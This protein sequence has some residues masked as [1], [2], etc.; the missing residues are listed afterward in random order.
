VS[1]IDADMKMPRSVLVAPDD[2]YIR[3]AGD[4]NSVGLLRDL[5]AMVVP[6]TLKP[7]LNEQQVLAV[8]ER[9]A[10]AGQLSRGAL[11][12]KNPYDSS[13]YVLAERAIETFARA[14]YDAIANVARL[15][16]AR[17][18]HFVEAKIETHTITWVA[19]IKA[20]LQGAA[21]DGS[22]T[23]EVKTRLKTRLEGLI[24]I[25]DPET[26][27][28][29]AMAY[30]ERCNLSGDLELMTLVR[31]RK[32]PGGLLKSRTMKM[33]G[34]QESEA[35]IRSALS[36]ANAGPMKAIQIAPSFTATAQSIREIEIIT[37]I[38]F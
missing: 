7:Q 33:S 27:P 9:L 11:L 31:M 17:E 25:S 5:N 35:N 34:T 20:K 37:E 32:G 23:R 2:L 26:A 10:A 3:L 38:K 21:A 15:L 22:T 13:T 4:P 12:I 1:E 8:R 14:K 29:D 36:I 16:G 6:Y 30:I 24:T 19:G 28:D 18:I